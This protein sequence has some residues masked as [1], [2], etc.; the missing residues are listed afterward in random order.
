[1]MRDSICNKADIA[2]LFEGKHT[3]N[4]ITL[5]IKQTFT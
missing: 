5:T 2:G 4:I 1:M 3:I